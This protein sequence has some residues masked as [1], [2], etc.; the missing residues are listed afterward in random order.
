MIQSRLNE[1]EGREEFYVHYVGCKYTRHLHYCASRF[2]HLTT[3]AII[4]CRLVI[5]QQTPGRMGGEGTPGPYQDREGRGEEEHRDRGHGWLGWTARKEDHSQPEAQTRWDQ[6][7]TEGMSL[8]YYF[9]LTQLCTE[10]LILSE[11]FLYRHMQRWTQQL[12]P[13]RKS[14]KPY[15]WSCVVVQLAPLSSDA[16]DISCR[17]LKKPF[18]LNPRLCFVLFS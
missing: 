14:T 18:H 7:C 13:W 11:A 10:L 9:L 8:V 6:P 12:L 1:Q 15:V 5:S 16:T 4:C 3:H 2:P 17:S